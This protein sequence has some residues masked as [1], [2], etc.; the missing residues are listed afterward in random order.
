M[1]IGCFRIERMNNC[2]PLARWSISWCWLLELE[3]HLSRAELKLLV[4]ELH[5]RRVELELLLA[6][7]HLRR[8][9]VNNS[10]NFVHL[11]ELS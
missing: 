9:E 3:L 11:E 1:T 4:S 5:L 6:E 2:H 7:L 10:P 8:V